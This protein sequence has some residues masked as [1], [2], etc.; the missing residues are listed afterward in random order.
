MIFGTDCRQ[1]AAR[2]KTI[3]TCHFSLKSKSLAGM[4]CS[5]R[6]FGSGLEFVAF[7]VPG[8]RHVVEVGD[9]DESRRV[10]IRGPGH[11]EGSDGAQDARHKRKVQ[12]R[13]E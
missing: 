2:R 13:K 12:V 3:F 6:P 4:S 10:C 8:Q 1:A 7:T 5:A 9:D 11:L